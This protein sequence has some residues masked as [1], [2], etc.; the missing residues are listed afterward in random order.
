MDTLA[1]R[2]KYARQRAGLTQE[3]LSARV[4]IRQPV[5]SRLERGQAK[6][7]YFLAQIAQACGVNSYWL[8]TG[9]FPDVGLP[10][11]VSANQKGSN[12]IGQ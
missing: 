3:E 5:Y 11:D 2:L 12:Q 6:R 4:G 7:S 9:Q 1:K 10:L 8:A